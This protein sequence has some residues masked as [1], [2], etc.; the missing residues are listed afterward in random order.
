MIQLAKAK[1]FFWIG[2]VQILLFK[3]YF[4]ERKV[5]EGTFVKAAFLKLHF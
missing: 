5:T 1:I 3:K 4:H 2:E